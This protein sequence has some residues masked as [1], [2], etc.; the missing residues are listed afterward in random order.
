MQLTEVEA[1]GVEVEIVVESNVPNAVDELSVEQ[2]I[3]AIMDA[4]TVTA[5][6][7]AAVAGS[8]SKNRLIST[9]PNQFI[10][11]TKPITPTKE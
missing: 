5:E 3:E 4:V 10:R 8:G 2:L 9:K 1:F 6:E 11:T 7:V